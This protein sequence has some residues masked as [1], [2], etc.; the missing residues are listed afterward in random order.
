MGK[1]TREEESKF[2]SSEY[3]KNPELFGRETFIDSPEFLET[4][5]ISFSENNSLPKGYLKFLPYD[6]IVEEISKE[7]GGSNS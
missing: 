2:L 3:D 4:I 1:K 5:G 7:K 6:F